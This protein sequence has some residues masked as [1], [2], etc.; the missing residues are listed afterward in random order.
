MRY[1]V[2]FIIF[3]FTPFSYAQDPDLPSVKEKTAEFKKLLLGNKKKTL[4][5]YLDDFL[6]ARTI[7]KDGS[8]YLTAVIESLFSKKASD[9]ELEIL[10][11]WVQ[12]DNTSAWARIL[13][14]YYYLNQLNRFAPA[15]YK[16]DKIDPL[17]KELIEQA[18]A[19]SEDAVRL[20][21]DNICARLAHFKIARY[22]GYKHEYKKRF[23]VLVKLYPQYFQAYLERLTQLS[24]QWG[25]NVRDL[26][27]FSKQTT[28]AY[29][30]KSV[31]KSLPLFAHKLMVEQSKDPI[32]YM[33]KQNV[34]EEIQEA[35]RLASVAFPRSS[36]YLR[37][38]A[39][40]A[41]VGKHEDLAERALRQ[42]EDREAGY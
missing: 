23:E 4:T 11:N 20:A 24:P 12:S 28:L 15:A 33:K 32:K 9:S 19:D 16:G 30:E 42:A 39:K 40:L 34:L 27:N 14:S 29:D 31:L 17:I 41:A 22:Q 13:R 8:H 2:F 35:E 37:L 10:N 18:A 6:S 3:L 26:M 7:A 38:F 5:Y 21:R 25:G 36:K 1:I